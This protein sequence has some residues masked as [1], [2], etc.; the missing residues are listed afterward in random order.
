MQ[1][2]RAAAIWLEYHRSHSRENTI[3]AYQSVLDILL[4]CPWL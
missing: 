3:R 4:I 1:V 2:S